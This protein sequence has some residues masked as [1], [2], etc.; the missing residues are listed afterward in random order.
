MRGF[1]FS[2]NAIKDACNRI[3][4]TSKPP[5]F[6]VADITEH[7]SYESGALDLIIDCFALIEIVSDIDFVF[8]EINRVLKPGGY[9]F[10]YTNSE[11]SEAY[12][13]YKNNNLQLNTYQYPDTK[14]VERVFSRQQ[15]DEMLPNFDCIE[16]NE[17]TRSHEYNGKPMMWHHIWT[18]YQKKINK[19]DWI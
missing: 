4:D 18:I 10:S 17:C 8:T 3:V 14:K 13:S 2:K 19:Y 16:Y 15:F 5:E 12:Q 6:V 9:F 11:L 1:D 7:W